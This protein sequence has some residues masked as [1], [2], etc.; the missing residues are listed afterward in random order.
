VTVDYD[1]LKDGTVTLRERDSM[2]QVRVPLE[3]VPGLLRKLTDMQVSWAD[4][5]GKYPQQAA[6]A[7]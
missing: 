4:V 1:T 2:L 6:P 3:E 7:E 5:Q